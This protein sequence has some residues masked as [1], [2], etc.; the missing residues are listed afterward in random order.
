MYGNGDKK[1]KKKKKKNEKT[2]IVGYTAGF[3][4]KKPI[5]GTK[6]EAKKAEK[7]GARYAK[8]AAKAKAKR[9]FGGGKPFKF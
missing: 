7:R 5:M 3:R 9:T 2:E 1:K 4:G 8:K 6:K